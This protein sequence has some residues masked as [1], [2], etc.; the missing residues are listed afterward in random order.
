[1]DGVNMSPYS[2]VGKSPS[3][4]DFRPV[5]N[6]FLEDEAAAAVS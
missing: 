2:A 6:A 5:E 4:S 3:Y 1:M